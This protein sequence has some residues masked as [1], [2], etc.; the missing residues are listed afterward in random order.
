[1]IQG[2][3][4]HIGGIHMN[5]SI[6]ANVILVILL[7]LVVVLAVLYFLGRKMEK[8]QVEQQSAI[9]AAKQTVSLMAID[10][11]KLK[12]KEAGLPPIVYEQ[13]PWYAKR[14]KV[15]VVKAK[16]G[17]KIMTMIADEKVFLQLPL[18]TE[19]KVV[20][21]G[22]YITEIKS[23]PRGGLI[24][25]PKKKTKSTR[26]DETKDP[27][28][29]WL[30]KPSDGRIFFYLPA[31]SFPCLSDIPTAKYPVRHERKKL[32]FRRVFHTSYHLLRSVL[33]T[34]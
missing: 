18:K 16:I 13:T 24:P 19:V 2:E 29:E 8:R 23:V 34:S 31:S 4:E 32:M 12:I 27:L 6:V 14:M 7:I 3:R 11:K 22:L 21:S 25:L 9:D 15:P 33:P 20:I 17:T 28:T 5:W 30:D 26:T 10:K 1:M